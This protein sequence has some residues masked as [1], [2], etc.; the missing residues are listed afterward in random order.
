MVWPQIVMQILTIGSNAPYSS[1]L[2]AETGTPVVVQS[3]MGPPQNDISVREKAT[4]LAECTSVAD[5]QTDN[6]MV[7]SNAFSDAA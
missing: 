4:A 1:T 6:V 5:G 7:T 2:P 3:R